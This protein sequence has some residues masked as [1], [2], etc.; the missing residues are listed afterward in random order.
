MRWN[1]YRNIKKREEFIFSSSLLLFFFL[2][3]FTSLFQRFIYHEKGTPLLGP[4][5]HMISGNHVFK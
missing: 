3:F 1:D 4:P 5:F 2:P